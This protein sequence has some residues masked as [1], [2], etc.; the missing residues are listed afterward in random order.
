MKEKSPPNELAYQY[1][2]TAQHPA[3][4]RKIA[5]IAYGNRKELGNQGGED[6]WRFKGRGLLQITGRENYGKI[7]EQI[8]QQAPDSG[9]NV[10]T[11]AIN[12][13][14]YTPYQAALT[15]MADWYKDKM[16]VK[17]DETGKFSDDGIVENIIEILN[18]GTTELSKNKRKVWY[19][20]GKEGKL[21]VAV[22]NS[23]KVLFKVAECGKVD[24]PLSFSEGRAPWME[25][26]IQEII[27]YG[28]KHEKAIDK[29][30]REYH[31]A[32]GLSGSGSKIARCASFVSWCLENSTPKFESPH[33]A[34]SSIFFNHSTLEPCEAFFGAIAVFSDCYSNGKMKG[35][36]HVTLVY[37][38]LLDKNTYIGLGGNQGNMITLS[39]NY[40][41]DGSTFYSYTEK[42]V[43]I[44]KKLR[45]FF[46]P[47]GYVIKEEDK[48]NKNDE[49]A[50]INEANKKLNQKT[51]DTSKGES[52]R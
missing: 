25:T 13:K 39:P 46:K 41:F 45:G 44:Y 29:R 43:K 16:Y 12:E 22:E 31:K 33:S 28:G 40:K 14:G 10:F 11:L 5:E 19:R 2:R 18:P 50:T 9:F 35:S 15:G 38:R 48:L 27:N 47:K 8:D 37:G 52:S 6:G 4:Q 7:Q 23:T 51:Q 32:G 17:A 24:E 26:A 34:S 20:G 1:G 30:I 21:S 42:G 3:N 36:G 49:Y